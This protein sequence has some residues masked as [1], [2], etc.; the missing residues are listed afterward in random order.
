MLRAGLYAK[1]HFVQY[2]A[3]IKAMG[4]LVK[5]RQSHRVKTITAEPIG[6]GRGVARPEHLGMT[7]KIV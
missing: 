5:I 2:A 6:R 4:S 7:L 1:L 3:I